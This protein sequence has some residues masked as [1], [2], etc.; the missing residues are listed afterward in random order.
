[1]PDGILQINTQYEQITPANWK[2]KK[3]AKS[4]TFKL[5]SKICVF[6]VL[7]CAG[8]LRVNTISRTNTILFYQKVL[9]VSCLFAVHRSPLMSCVI[10][11]ICLFAEM[12]IDVEL[13]ESSS[14][15]EWSNKSALYI[16]RKLNVPVFWLGTK[17][18]RRYGEHKNSHRRMC[19][20]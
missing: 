10:G 19:E 2:R 8:D 1:M 15:N 7:L 16:I 14:N 5:Y 6:M 12:E 13:I 18:H 17:I 9:I 20:A 11:W 3:K 4:L